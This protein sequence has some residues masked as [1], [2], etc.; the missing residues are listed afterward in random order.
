MNPATG[1][2]PMKKNSRDSAKLTQQKPM[3][4]RLKAR[5][6]IERYGVSRVV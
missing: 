3:M 2:A 4:K 6:V 5:G 1:Q